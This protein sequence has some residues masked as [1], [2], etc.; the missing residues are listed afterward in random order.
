MNFRQKSLS[1]RLGLLVL[2]ALS[3]IG[4]VLFTNARAQPVSG[5]S[6]KGELQILPLKYQPAA[7][8]NIRLH[9]LLPSAMQSR[10]R[11]VAE[12]RTNSLLVFGTPEQIKLIQSYV[13]TLDVNRPAHAQPEEPWQVIPLRHLSEDPA[14]E[15]VLQM[16]GSRFGI[17]YALD[18][19]R[20]A[21]IIIGDDQTV[22][23]VRG[24]VERIESA[25]RV[26]EKVPAQPAHREIQV[27]L[28]W[29]VSGAARLADKSAQKALSPPPSDL[30]EVVAELGRIGIEDLHLVSQVV[31]N[32]TE[33]SAFST[34]A[35][36]YFMGDMRKLTIQGKAIA[37][38]GRESS[39]QLSLGA[40]SSPDSAP[41]QICRLE[42]QITVPFGHFVVLGVTPTMAVTS[43][44]V[45]QVTPKK[46]IPPTAQP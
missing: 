11:I 18:R 13:A 26:V 23:A 16:V 5:S 12:D 36:A 32:A 9:E 35:A 31:M 27:R 2:L 20:Q 28:V 8:V 41:G 4:C 45:V 46:T 21:L 24:L 7:E 37:R 3:G 29:L 22:R 10:M 17:Q 43:A 34:E 6:P 1:P 40:T 30:K 44:F 38:G 19:Q 33:G 39:L 25:P 14:F 15:K 42:T